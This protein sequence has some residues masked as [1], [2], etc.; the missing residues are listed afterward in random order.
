[1]EYTYDALTYDVK[2]TSRSTIHH[3]WSVL[4]D[5]RIGTTM[6]LPD[7]LHT[8][9]HPSKEMLNRAIIEYLTMYSID[10]VVSSASTPAMSPIR[11]KGRLI[12]AQLTSLS[13][14]NDSWM[15]TFR[16]DAYDHWGRQ[17]PIVAMVNVLRSESSPSVFS[18]RIA[19]ENF[20]RECLISDLQCTSESGHHDGK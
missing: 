17:M 4:I 16:I 11:F 18:L 5:L 8:P 10:D 2:L 13:P 14:T 9:A 1:M 20:L 12:D 3:A 15:V 19:L 7:M 6:E